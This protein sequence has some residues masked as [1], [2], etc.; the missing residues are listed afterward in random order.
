MKQQEMD[1]IEPEP[2]SSGQA[3]PADDC[4]MNEPTG[5]VAQDAFS[6]G[7][8]KDH[9][10]DALSE[11]RHRHFP[12]VS[13]KSWNDWRWQLKHRICRAADLEK[14]LKLSPAEQ[15][16]VTLE[17]LLPLSITP[18]YMSL[19]HETD[20][21]DPIRKCVIPTAQELIR[22][23]GEE[24]DPLQEDRDSPVPGIIHRYPDRV[25]FL[26]TGFCSTYC[27]YCTRSRIVGQR[28]VYGTERWNLGMEYV[29][30]NPQVRDVLISGGDPLTINDDQLEYLLKGLRQIRHVEIIRIGS[31]VPA[32]LP[33]RITRKLCAML[34][35]YHP[36]FMS[37]HFTHPR[38]LTAESM[39]ACAR[40]A[41]AGIPLGSQTV[42]LKGI[43][44][45]PGIMKKLN[46]IL[47]QARVRPYY[48][49][50]CDPVP[51]SGRFRTTMEKGLEV[52]RSLRGHTSGYAVPQYVVDLPGG[53]GKIP[54][55]PGYYQ[56]RSEQGQVFRNFENQVYVYPENAG[57]NDSSGANLVSAHIYAG[58]KQ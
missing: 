47:L 49:Y 10:Q 22:G 2:P 19:V 54:L 40:L 5:L 38:E 31:K 3:R 12:G 15:E 56:G 14:Y 20:S 46:Q 29:R 58:G 36:L 7:A 37:L 16:A 32:V 4:H 13:S 1:E 6:R 8:E 35:K 30:S 28:G 24:D 55:L 39:E 41:E 52:I 57:R 53:G 17:N 43:N 23:P 18:Y 9:D 34:K 26:A 25:L 50:Q 42:L 21:D 11:F 27:R 44:D 45:K 48:L 33:Q 51:G